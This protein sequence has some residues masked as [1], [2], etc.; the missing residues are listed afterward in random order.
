MIAVKRLVRD[1]VRRPRLIRRYD[2]TQD[3]TDA[4]VFADTDFEGCHGTRRSTN[5]G[6]ILLGDHALRHWSVTQP[7]IAL[8]SGEA[9]LIGI[10][11]GAAQGL[12]LQSMARDLRFALTLHLFTHA[13]AA[14]GICLQRCLGRIRHLSCSDL[15]VQ[16]RRRQGDVQPSKVPRSE[17]PADASAE[18]IDSPTLLRLLPLMALEEEQG[19]P[20]SAPRL[21]N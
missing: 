7:P 10:V 18:H 4:K 12:G 14:I 9:D 1:L 13:T 8:S 17:N 20:D 6:V 15:L 11:R 16:E 19:R 21:Q 3:A 5:G 2:W